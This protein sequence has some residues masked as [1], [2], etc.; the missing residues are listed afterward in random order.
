MQNIVKI[1]IVL[2]LLIISETPIYSESEIKV[3]INS[4]KE[5]LTKY[6]KVQKIRTHLNFVKVY[7]E[8]LKWGQVYKHLKEVYNICPELT[9]L[10]LII[11]SEDDYNKAVFIHPKYI[12]A[13]SQL[14]IK[15]VNTQK[16]FFNFLE[17]FIPICKESCQDK[18]E[19]APT[20]NN[21]E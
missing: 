10:E 2:G 5:S 15:N 13:F 14:G 8:N 18:G 19:I 16:E 4:V 3:E 6:N 20:Q 17:I 12:K 7:A 1:I 11:P 21:L 9:S